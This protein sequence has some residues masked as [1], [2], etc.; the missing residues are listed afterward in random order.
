ML[1][2]L[3]MTS[4]AIA[5]IPRNSIYF[6]LLGP[7]VI[8]SLNYERYFSINEKSHLGANVG[9]GIYMASQ[10]G[11][12]LTNL[13]TQIPYTIKVG[14]GNYMAL[15]NPGQSYYITQNNTGTAITGQHYPIRVKLGTMPINPK[16][17]IYTDVIT[18]TVTAW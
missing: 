2:I 5:Q 10:N 8:L 14:N 16:N 12:K 18:V 13:P 9:F 6:E 1:L 15:S 3:M 11:S 7:G 17:G 4:H